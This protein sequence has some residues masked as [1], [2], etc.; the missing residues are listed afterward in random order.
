MRVPIAAVGADSP[1]LPRYIAGLALTSVGNLATGDM[2]RIL[3]QDAEKSLRGS[4]PYLKKKAALV[5]I[6]IF[7]RV[8]EMVEE[9]AEKIVSLLKEKY[10]K[11]LRIPTSFPAPL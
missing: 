11:L 6:R 8:P 4:N 2:G 7:K 10:A 9:F 5:M 1:V 3:I